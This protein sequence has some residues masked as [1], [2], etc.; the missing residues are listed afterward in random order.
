[1][2][3]AHAIERAGLGE[4]DFVG[5]WDADLATPLD[6]IPPFA[7]ILEGSRSM[8]MVFG[9]RVALLGRDIQRKADRHYLGRIFATLAS[10]VLDLRIYD[11]QCG[12]KL[13]RVTQDLR[14]ALSRPFTSGWIFD[15]ELIARFIT[16]K[17]AA[18]ATPCHDVIYEYPLERWHDVAGSKLGFMSKINALY[19]L[20]CIYYSYF[21][22][23]RSWPPVPP[24]GSG[25]QQV[26]L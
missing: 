11:T 17:V 2:G 7:R 10:M 1:M 23:F 25:Q 13:F 14:L 12:A 4:G 19:G 3:M 22:P 6:T 20:G 9:A 8:E 21:S 26:E 16:Q 5:F 24:G 15:V 18:G